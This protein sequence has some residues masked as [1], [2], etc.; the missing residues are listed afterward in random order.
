MPHVFQNVIK[1]WIIT[2]PVVITTR[3]GSHDRTHLQLHARHMY[4]ITWHTNLV[5]R[6]GELEVLVL[7]VA[8]ICHDLDHPGYNNIY[9]INARTELALR[10]NDISPLEN[11]HCSIAFRLL[12]HPECNIFRNMS[13]EMFK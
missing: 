9:Q 6:L 12:E 11:H 7:L 10:Y 8:C 13:K 3:G 5:Q 2:H 1:L 4:A